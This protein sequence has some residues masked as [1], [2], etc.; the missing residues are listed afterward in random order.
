MFV[1]HP[2]VGRCVGA[3][4]VIAFVAVAG[5]LVAGTGV[6]AVAEQLQQPVM[7]RVGRKDN[8][9]DT[10][11]EGGAVVARASSLAAGVTGGVCCARV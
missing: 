7:L 1:R 11:E 4:A 10:G 5:A 3:N 6:W 8:G 2:G 9:C